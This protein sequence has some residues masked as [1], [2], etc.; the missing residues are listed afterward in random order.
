MI[1]FKTAFLKSERVDKIFIAPQSLFSHERCEGI[2]LRPE[3]YIK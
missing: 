3:K 2:N 1:S